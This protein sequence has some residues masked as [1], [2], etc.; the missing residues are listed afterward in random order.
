MIQD[1]VGWP[2]DRIPPEEWMG[3]ELC[4]VIAREEHAGDPQRTGRLMAVKGKMLYV[5]YFKDGEPKRTE[6]QV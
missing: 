1:Y 5:G 2:L 4:P 6:N 3:Y